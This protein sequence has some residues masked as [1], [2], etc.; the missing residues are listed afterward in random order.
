N[1]L[2]MVIGSRGDIEAFLGIARHLTRKLP[3]RLR[4][5]THPSHQEAVES[6]GLEFY[7]V[8]GDPNDY[9]DSWNE[10]PELFSSAA[11]LTQAR[12]G[13]TWKAHCA[14]LREYWVSSISHRPASASQTTAYSDAKTKNID[15]LPE[16]ARPF[17]ADIIVASLPT[18]LHIHVAQKLRVPLVLVSVQPVLPTREFP[19]SLSMTKPSFKPGALRNYLSSYSI[20]L[21]IWIAFGTSVNAI[22]SQELHL[23]PVSWLWAV[24]DLPK[25]KIP[26]VCLWSRHLVPCPSEWGENVTI[27]GYTSND[28]GTYYSPP[29]ALED[30]LLTSRPIIAISFG[31]AKIPNEVHFLGAI[32]AAV[33]RMGVSA[34]VCGAWT[35]AARQQITGT[36]DKALFFIDRVP[37]GWLLQRVQGFI[38]HGGAGHMAAGLRAGVPMLIVPL[39]LDQHFWAAQVHRHGLGPPPLN[40]RS[41][42]EDCLVVAL[43]ELLFGQYQNQCAEMARRLAA[44]AD[45]GATAADLI[46]ENLRSTTTK[47][48]TCSLLP[49]LQARWRHRTSGKPLSGVAAASL[50]AHGS[51]SWTELELFPHVDWTRQ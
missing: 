7:S 39:F 20:E 28:D 44:D 32:S 17:V 48:P 46:V 38:H 18:M 51:L 24:R 30:F 36:S 13:D 43:R 3:C 15:D 10:H 40:H 25:L 27:G 2:F 47:S 37:H 34:V 50:V 4:V 5:A 22:R 19:S 42:K 6:H 14:M 31:S 29:R 21:I 12:L 23:K 11:S 33:N 8:G 41:I 1:V 26:H 49:T 16:N 45:G 35:K 9:A